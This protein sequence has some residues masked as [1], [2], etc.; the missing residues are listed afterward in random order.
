MSTNMVLSQIGI[1]P[2]RAMLTM[3]STRGN[4]WLLENVDR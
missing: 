3:V 1:S 2:R 4:I